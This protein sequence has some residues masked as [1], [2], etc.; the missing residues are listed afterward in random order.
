MGE[1]LNPNCSEAVFRF[2]TLDPKKIQKI[3]QLIANEIS[4]NTEFEGHKHQKI[5]L[6]EKAEDYE[7]K[8]REPTVEET[9]E[10]FRILG[11]II[12]KRDRGEISHEEYNE[13]MA[14]EYERYHK[15]KYPNAILYACAGLGDNEAVITIEKDKGAFRLNI[16][17]NDISANTTG[18]IEKVLSLGIRVEE[19][20]L[21]PELKKYAR[22]C[23]CG[24][25]YFGV[26][27]DENA[28]VSD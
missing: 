24:I 13:E 25:I 26:K 8:Y 21:N 12:D 1:I 28:K 4:F 11:E 7:T 15:K 17:N 14:K 23:T 20:E 19:A 18:W 5:P 27:V 6:F 10:H 16:G 22:D 9:N 2:Y 3:L